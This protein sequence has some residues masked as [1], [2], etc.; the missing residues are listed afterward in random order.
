MKKLILTAAATALMLTLA[1]CNGNT[2]SSVRLPLAS[3]AE[4]S[5][6]SQAEETN[7]TEEQSSTKEPASTEETNSTELSSN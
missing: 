6:S 7:S 3:A 2:I 5:S 1:G 4:S